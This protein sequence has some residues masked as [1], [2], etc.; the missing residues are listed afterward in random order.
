MYVNNESDSKKSIPGASRHID[1]KMRRYEDNY[2]FL[3]FI[4]T[5]VIIEKQCVICSSALASKIKKPSKLKRHLESE[6][7]KHAKFTNK[8]T[9]LTAKRKVKKKTK[10]R[11]TQ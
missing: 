3:G 10:L 11:S 4:K 1:T 8:L 2:L 5:V 6:E 7:S 9:E